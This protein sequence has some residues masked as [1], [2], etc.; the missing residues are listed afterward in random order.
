MRSHLTGIGNLLA[1]STE[2]SP[3]QNLRG[4]AQNL[5]ANC[6]EFALYTNT[7]I[8]IPIRP[9]PRAGC[10]MTKFKYLASRP[11]AMMA[12]FSALP[13][14]KASP[15]CLM[16]VLPILTA[17]DAWYSSGLRIG[18]YPFMS[19]RGLIRLRTR[20]RRLPIFWNNASLARLYPRL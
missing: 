8:L 2:Q 6:A 14:K 7:Y 13:I 12:S 9:T 5:P 18:V 19:L 11:L 10:R 1:Y 16:G 15:E 20:S 4:G 3:A 17:G